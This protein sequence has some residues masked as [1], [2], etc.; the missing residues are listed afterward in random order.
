MTAI[1]AIVSIFT[2]IAA[3]WIFRIV[4]ISAKAI[5]I[6]R[7]AIST[8]KDDN[9]SDIEREKALQQ[10]SIRLLGSFFSILY[11]AVL[12]LGAC[13]FPILVADWLELV[14]IEDVTVFLLRI[15]VILITT[16][17]LL[18]VYFIRKRL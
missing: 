6:Y 12:T 18:V 1:T 16:I 7:E 9:F 8:M 17:V 15:D 11:R 2:F 10:A 14:K 5:S 13:F 3:L 4:P